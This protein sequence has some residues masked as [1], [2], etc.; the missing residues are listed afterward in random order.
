MSE[1]VKLRFMG[2]MVEYVSKYMKKVKSRH[3]ELFQKR[4]L[5]NTHKISIF[6]LYNSK[7]EKFAEEFSTSIDF[8]FFCDLIFDFFKAS[9]EKIIKNPQLLTQDF[10]NPANLNMDVFKR[11]ITL[12]NYA[13]VVTDC[14]KLIVKSKAYGCTS[15]IE[16]V[17]GNLATVL[18]L[19]SQQ[20]KNQADL[21]KIILSLLTLNENR[22][23]IS[24]SASM[25]QTI[26]D[27]K[28]S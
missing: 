23:A 1:A 24:Q 5:D 9:G 13:S 25:T 3:T 28:E 10:K 19:P 4:G 8:T 26:E 22:D 2:K 15:N 21:T 17:A 18:L 16:K 27:D 11:R 7:K 12:L 20:S 14:M 6:K